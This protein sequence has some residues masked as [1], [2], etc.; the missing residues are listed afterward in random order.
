MDTD[1]GFN[2]M[3]WGLA[4]QAACLGKGPLATSYRPP[5]ETV[6]PFCGEKFVGTSCP[7]SACAKD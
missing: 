4:L 2:L 5:L 1:G 7:R 6:C 3:D